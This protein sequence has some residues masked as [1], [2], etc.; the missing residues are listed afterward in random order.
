MEVK[1]LIMDR[2]SREVKAEDERLADVDV[3]LYCVSKEQKN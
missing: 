2:I 1:V 3:A